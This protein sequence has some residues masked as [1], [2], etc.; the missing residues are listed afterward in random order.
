MSLITL[1]SVD[2]TYGDRKLLDGVSLL[3]GEGDRI[4]LVG[5][6]GAGKST[7]LRLL[8]GTEP[9]DEGRRTVRRDLRIGY[10]PQDPLLDPDA[11]VRAMV[12]AGLAGR[13]EVLSGLDRVHQALA[14]PAAD[15]ATVERLLAEQ[16]RLEDRLHGLGGHD[17]EHRIESIVHGVGLVDLDA[18][19]GVLSGGER[20]RVALARLLV[21]APELLLL[22]EPTNHLDAET[23]DW[24]EDLLL[25]SASALVLV[26]HD[27]YFLDR[28]VTRIVEVDRAAL[29][30]YEGGYREYVEQRAARLERE[31]RAEST[32]LNLLRRETAWI[33]R[34]APARTTKS[35]A[36]I[37]RYEALVGDAPEQDERELAF[38]IPCG[39]RL[40]EKVL[41]ARGIGKAFGPRQVLDGLDLEIGRGDRIGI[42]GP[43]GAGKST[44]LRIL[45]GL[46]EPDAGAVDIGPTVKFSYV[47]QKREGLDPSHTV[48]EE[49]GRG[50]DHI[51]VAGR[52]MRVESFLESML[53]PGSRA[54]TR[55]GDLS[56]GER[57]RVLLAKLLATAGNVLVLDEPTNDLDLTTLQVL[58]EAIVAFPGAALVVSHDR[59]FLD[60]IATRIVHLG[61]DGR[62]RIWNGDLSLLLERLAE[63]RRAAEEAERQARRPAAPAAGP[64]SPE[65]DR[66]RR[67]SNWER[68]ELDELPDRIAGAER[69]IAALDARLAD[70][71]LYVANPGAAR[72]LGAERGRAQREVDALYAR[73]EELEERA[74]GS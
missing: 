11:S 28:V 38:Q 56:G 51:V 66:P 71:Q 4:G 14:D 27:R 69:G 8:A 19:C 70:P 48:I 72:E 59:W 40:G 9:P 18:R 30:G 3:V 67:L 55:V 7:L 60:R 50:N 22:D 35:R 41:I 64:D 21:D 74:D 58:E 6:N 5:P 20:R 68:R 53:F 63:E 37:D 34:G 52:A 25:Q 62:H 61:G 33:R 24:L 23:I 15:H 1:E 16:T 13:E 49:V 2:K 31:A 47:D 12:R 46:L 39:Q 10:L 65:R 44:L 73:W 36:R 45:M 29:F 26:T 42:V 54:R 17:I 32:R 43:N 57:N